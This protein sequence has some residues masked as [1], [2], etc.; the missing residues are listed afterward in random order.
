MTITQRLRNLDRRAGVYKQATPAQWRRMARAWRTGIGGACFLALM[1][2]GISI[3][4][5]EAAAAV[6]PMAFLAVYLAFQAGQ[7]KVEDDRLRGV[8]DRVAGHRRPDGL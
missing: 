2:V 1:I 6:T 5:P 3:I 4:V 7:M 8:V